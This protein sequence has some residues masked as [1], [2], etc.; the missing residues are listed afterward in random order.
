LLL[1]RSSSSPFSSTVLDSVLRNIRISPGGDRFAYRPVQRPHGDG[2]GESAYQVVGPI[3]T[4]KQKQRSV[5][6]L[7]WHAFRATAP[8]SGW[9]RSRR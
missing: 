9:L 6:V 7:R 2:R 8:R 5:T 3:D 4:A 1:S